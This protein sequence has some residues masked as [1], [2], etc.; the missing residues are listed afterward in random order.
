[1]D[2]DGE[3]TDVPRNIKIFISYA[4]ESEP[5]KAWVASVATRL[6]REGIHAILDRWDLGD[7]DIPSFMNRW[8][9]DADRVLMIGS[10]QYRDKVHAMESRERVTGSGWESGLLTAQLF[11]DGADRR[12]PIV[13]AIG[14]GTWRDAFPTYVVSRDHVDL[15]QNDRFEAEWERLK[16]RLLDQVPSGPEVGPA[17]A[18]ALTP[19]Y[20]AAT[21]AFQSEESSGSGPDADA[22][23][24]AAAFDS[25]EEGADG[26]PT[27]EFDSPIPRV[28]GFPCLAQVAW[29]FSHPPHLAVPVAE[30]LLLTTTPSGPAEIKAGD[31]GELKW[32]EAGGLR[33]QP[34]T[35]AWVPN[36]GSRLVLLRASCKTLVKRFAMCGPPARVGAPWAV[37]TQQEGDQAV[38]I[39]A[40]G[41]DLSELA[42]LPTDLGAVAG[43]PIMSGSHLVGIVHARQ[44]EDGLLWAPLAG[45]LC[46]DAWQAQLGIDGAEPQLAIRGGLETVLGAAAEPLKALLMT[47]LQVSTDE[48]MANELLVRSQPE[49]TKLFAT[50]SS[51]LIDG[52]RPEALDDLRKIVNY[53]LPALADKAVSHAMRLNH[54][55]GGEALTD[56]DVGTATTAEALMAAFDGRPMELRFFDDGR[57]PEGDLALP[58]VP[59]SGIDPEGKG[60]AEAFA[61]HFEN[62][63]PPP[64]EEELVKLFG[65]VI[66]SRAR[67]PRRVDVESERLAYSKKILANLSTAG[68]TYYLL[69]PVQKERL[70]QTLAL[71]ERLKQEFPM[72]MFLALPVDVTREAEDAV[73]IRNLTKIYVVKS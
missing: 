21:G 30:D 37:L 62:K 61:K 20:T 43:G 19:E 52:K 28:E 45:Y 23:S 24:V 41:E 54:T 31:T 9:R 25:A 26:G 51:R 17:P 50:L 60:F 71:I 34:F 47:E 65:K 15:T 32:G 16:Q 1:M 73:L 8:V 18:T 29:G 39:G 46:Q 42:D 6:R 40:F 10:P 49:L 35:V 2:G 48:A 27:H 63:Y 13:T 44:S 12:W 53:A 22:V 36:D 64:S 38:A 70:S 11:T 14:R 56:A 59:T 5:Y 33:E 7:Q 69:V 72:I 66:V 4:W 3:L 55:V 68:E 67:I 57:P 58:G